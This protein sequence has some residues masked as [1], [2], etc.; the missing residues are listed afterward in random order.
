MVVGLFKHSPI[1]FAIDVLPTPGG[2]VNSNTIPDYEF[3][4]LF[5]AINSRILSFVSIIP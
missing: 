2:P 4:L 5:F 3:T 1:D